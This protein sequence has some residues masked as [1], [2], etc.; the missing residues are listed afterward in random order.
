MDLDNEE[1]LFCQIHFSGWISYKSL[2]PK[3]FN[4]PTEL[5]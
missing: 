2:T 1:T 4:G 5:G 3:Y